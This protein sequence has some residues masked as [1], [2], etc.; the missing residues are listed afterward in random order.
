MREVE[1][2]GVILTGGDTAKAVCKQ[3]G[4]SGIQLIKE[5]EPGIPLGKLVGNAPLWVVTKAG[6]FGNE[7]SLLHAKNVL[8]GEQS[9]E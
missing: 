8:K 1:L 9:N 3:L 2:Q 7:N 5:I 6:A 4:V